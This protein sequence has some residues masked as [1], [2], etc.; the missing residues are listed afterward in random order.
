MEYARPL[1][2]NSMIYNCNSKQKRMKNYVIKMYT[3]F[4][5]FDTL[6][7]ILYGYLFVIH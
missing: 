4:P 5:S 2:D 1:I 3:L 6:L 7:D